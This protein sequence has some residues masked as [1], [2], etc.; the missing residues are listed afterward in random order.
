MSL[1]IRDTRTEVLNYYATVPLDELQKDLTEFTMILDLHIYSP[2]GGTRM[3]QQEHEQ[4]L[5]YQLVG[6]ENPFCPIC[7]RKLEG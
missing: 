6:C 2:T 3:T 7:G 1:H 4:S 5:T